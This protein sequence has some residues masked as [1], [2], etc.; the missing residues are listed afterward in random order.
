[1]KKLLS[2]FRFFNKNSMK[3]IFIHY[4]KEIIGLKA[5]KVKDTSFSVM[6]KVQTDVYLDRVFVSYGFDGLQTKVFCQAFFS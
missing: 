4:W 1:M 3:N 2:T 6:L 5:F